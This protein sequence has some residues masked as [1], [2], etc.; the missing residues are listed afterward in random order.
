MHV[1]KLSVKQELSRTDPRDAL[2]LRAG[3]EPLIHNSFLPSPLVDLLTEKFNC[4]W[5]TTGRR[6]CGEKG[7]RRSW[8]SHTCTQLL[9]AMWEEA[10]ISAFIHPTAT[11]ECHVCSG[12]RAHSGEQKKAPAPVQ[13]TAREET[14]KGHISISCNLGLKRCWETNGAENRSGQGRPHRRGDI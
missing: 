11:M 10:G 9:G 4:H 14:D 13:L 12:S 2:H 5:D 8:S 1:G 3:E 6:G 7:S